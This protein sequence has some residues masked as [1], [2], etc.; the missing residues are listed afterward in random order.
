MGDEQQVSNDPVILALIE[1]QLA[2]CS[3]SAEEGAAAAVG[4][5]FPEEMALS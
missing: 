5:T 4:E 3:G 2:G 1:K